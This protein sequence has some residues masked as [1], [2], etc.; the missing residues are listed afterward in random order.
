[1]RCLGALSVTLP[2]LLGN[3]KK[4]E[5]GRQIIARVQELEMQNFTSKDD[6][7]VAMLVA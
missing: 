4:L 7:L 2:A 1:M 3:S 6:F 5:F